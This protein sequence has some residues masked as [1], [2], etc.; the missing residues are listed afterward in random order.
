MAG[1]LN[2]AGRIK[3]EEMDTITQLQDKLH[4]MTKRLAH[5]IR[6]QMHVPC[7]L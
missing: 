6:L 2:I 5:E 4:D 7:M 1:P 3:E